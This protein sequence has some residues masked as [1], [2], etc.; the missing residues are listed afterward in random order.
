MKRASPRI[1]RVGQG[2]RLTIIVP[3]AEAE[4]AYTAGL[5]DGEGSI[6]TVKHQAKDKHRPHIRWTCRVSLIHEDTI[7]WLLKTWGGRYYPKPQRPPRAAQHTWAVSGH[8]NCCAFLEAVRP[9]L[10][11]K[12]RRADM[13]LDRLGPYRNSLRA[14]LVPSAPAQLPPSRETR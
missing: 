14:G 1:S 2:A 8:L 11:V 6:S 5:F 12:A 3:T 9:F 10:I 4:L 7:R 13:A